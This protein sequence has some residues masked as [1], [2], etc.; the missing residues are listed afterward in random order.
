MSK[1]KPR[2]A[3]DEP[4]GVRAWLAA[5][6]VAAITL[7][8]GT[9]ALARHLESGDSRA[10]AAGNAS[11]SS[12]SGPSSTS[13]ASPTACHSSHVAVDPAWRTSLAKAL[14]SWPD[15]G[16]SE[17][18]A[19]VLDPVQSATVA[20]AGL[21]GATAWVPEDPAWLASTK[22]ATLKALK[23]TV[24]GSS[25]LVVVNPA[26][27]AKAFKVPMDATTL[28]PLLVLKETWANHGHSDWGRL[29]LVLPD[30]N[31]SVAGASAFGQLSSR[32]ATAS[33]A[34]PAQFAMA[35]TQQRIVELTSIDKV[36]SS[37]A[38]N[39]ADANGLTPAGP[40]TGVTTEA[41]ALESTGASASYLDRA[42][43]IAL[44][45]VNPGKDE[46]VN[47]LGTWLA[48]PEG[49]AA[50]AGAGVRTEDQAP[51]PE[52]LA[53]LGLDGKVDHPRTP[54]PA[55]VAKA[56]GLLAATSARSAAMLVLDTS[57]SMANPL[58]GGT[59]R[60]IDI[61]LKMALQGWE[62]WPPG[63][64][65]GLMTFHS[66]NDDAMAP[67]VETLVP[68][69]RNDSAQWVKAGSQFKGA[70]NGITVSGG[71]PLYQAILGAYAYQQKAYVEGMPNKLV[72]V[73]DG[74]SEDAA[75]EP[76]LDALLA[77][78][79]RTPDPKHPIKV[80]YVA[81]G[82]DADIET[83]QKIAAATGQQAVQVTS[84]ADLQQK[85]GILFQP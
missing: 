36:T 43:A 63:M 70:L 50:L 10:Q 75:G 80:I 67:K 20:S 47:G 61:V 56:R 68:L 16:P 17:C 83:L 4:K 66:T 9:I 22:D 25:P 48:S 59:E 65:T 64:A 30:P 44:S 39:P 33:A 58:P 74:R 78:L 55:D 23:P 72:I 6:A 40:R 81:L 31:S 62:Q 69:M 52:S 13:S 37:L 53:T 57:G 14:D 24:L 18:P 60:K 2:H 82:Q 79:P 29:K 76:S 46:K 49:R 26:E 42:S 77:K 8:G 34:V 54:Q 84:M 73:T 38:A 35:A 41:L 45:L 71:T 3:V 85:M 5:G 32:G 27:A 12:P 51:K 1:S 21:S 7:S 28:T 19:V 11:S 15:K